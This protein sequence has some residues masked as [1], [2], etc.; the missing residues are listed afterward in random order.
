MKLSTFLAQFEQRYLC[1]VEY[2]STTCREMVVSNKDNKKID[3]TSVH[4][5]QYCGAQGYI[6]RKLTPGRAEIHPIFE[7]VDKL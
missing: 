6:V 3:V 7:D 5:F 2:V 4:P 1:T